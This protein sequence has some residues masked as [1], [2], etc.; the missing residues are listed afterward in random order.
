M[1]SHL[2]NINAIAENKHLL[3][4]DQL[5][6]LNNN[7]TNDINLPLNELRLTEQS[8]ETYGGSDSN[9]NRSDYKKCDTSASF[10]RCATD[11]AMNKSNIEKRD[12]KSSY[13]KSHCRNSSYDGLLMHSR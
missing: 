4:Q 5:N 10:N 13:V 3:D 6:G 9:V 12:R 2:K 8:M 7:V 11:S 1:S